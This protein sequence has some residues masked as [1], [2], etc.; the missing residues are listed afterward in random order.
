[1]SSAHLSLFAVEEDALRQLKDDEALP[2]L[3]NGGCATV[4]QYILLSVSVAFSRYGETVKDGRRLENI[5]WRLWHKALNSSEERDENVYRPPTPK[6]ASRPLGKPWLLYCGTFAQSKVETCRR[7]SRVA[8][9]LCELLPKAT[10][11][12][13]TSTLTI[14]QSPINLSDISAPPTASPPTPESEI[15][16]EPCC[17]PVPPDA[18]PVIIANRH[19]HYSCSPVVPQNILLPPPK[20]VIVD[21]TPNPTP[22]PTPPTTPVVPSYLHAMKHDASLALTATVAAAY[23]DSLTVP[24]LCVPGHDAFQQAQMKASSR[25][26][27]LRSPVPEYGDEHRDILSN[28]G[29]RLFGGRRYPRLYTYRRAIVNSFVNDFCYLAPRYSALA[30]YSDHSYKHSDQVTMERVS[31]SPLPS[32]PSNSPPLPQPI[33]AA[34]VVAAMGDSVDPMIRDRHL[35]SSVLDTKTDSLFS[36]PDVTT[37]ATTAM[38]NNSMITTTMVGTEIMTKSLETRSLSP[39]PALCDVAVATV[40]TF[41]DLSLSPVTSTRNQIQGVN[42]ITTTN[43]NSTIVDLTATT[44]PGDDAAAITATIITGA[45]TGTTPAVNSSANTDST[46]STT[47]STSTTVAINPDTTLTLSSTASFSSASPSSNRHP[48]APL[49]KTRS[50]SASTSNGTGSSGHRNR[51][52]SGSSSA[53]RVLMSERKGV[54]SKNTSRSKMGVGRITRVGSDGSTSTV[55]LTKVNLPTTPTTEISTVTETNTRSTD[56]D[57]DTQI[58]ANTKSGGKIPAAANGVSSSSGRDQQNG[59]TQKRTLSGHAATRTPTFA[60]GKHHHTSFT[61]KQFSHHSHTHQRRHPQHQLVKESAEETKPAIVNDATNGAG[62]LNLGSELDDGSGTKSTKKMRSVKSG[63]ESGN[64]S[65]SGGLGGTGEELVIRQQQ[66]QQQEKMNKKEPGEEEEKEKSWILPI[67]KSPEDDAQVRTLSSKEETFIQDKGKA[68]F[69]PS[70]DAINSTATANGKPKYPTTTKKSSTVVPSLHVEATL[71]DPLLPRTTSRKIVVTSGSEDEDDEDFETETEA[72]TDCTGTV[73]RTG[74][75]SAFTDKSYVKGK[76]K[77]KEREGVLSESQQKLKVQFEL[78]QQK[79]K[80]M[81]EQQRVQ[82]RLQVQAQQQVTRPRPRPPLNRTQSHNPTRAT[83]TTTHKHAPSRAH[84]QRALSEQQRAAEDRKWKEELFTKLPTSSFQDSVKI[85]RTNSVPGL[86]S[87]LL[88]PDLQML[89]VDPSLR[90][91]SG[92]GNVGAG[93]DKRGFSSGMIQPLKLLMPLREG[94]QEVEEKIV[95][96]QGQQV[97]PQVIKQVSVQPPHQHEAQQ[98]PP[99]NECTITAEPHPQLQPQE[100]VATPPTLSQP[101]LVDKHPVN[102]VGGGGNQR[103]QHSRTVSRTYRLPKRL[104]VLTIPGGGGAGIGGGTTKTPVATAVMSELRVGSIQG[105]KKQV[106]IGGDGALV[107]ADVNPNA[108][109]SGSGSGGATGIGKGRYKSK[110]PPPE[111]VMEDT[112]GEESDD[113]ENQLDLPKSVAQEK[114]RAL[115]EGQKLKKLAQGTEQQQSQANRQQEVEHRPA[116][117]ISIPPPR[118]YYPYNLPPPNPPTSPRTTR[119]KMLTVE[120]PESLRRNLLWE[121][122]VSQAHRRGLKRSASSGDVAKGWEIPNVVKLTPKWLKQEPVDEEKERL[123]ESR[124][125]YLARTRTW[126]FEYHGAGW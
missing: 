5:S 61:R 70:T 38:S 34:T 124:R 104:E 46:T 88:K 87:R 78:Q 27:H 41:E 66:Q 89:P 110:A 120:I 113:D 31:S 80:Q 117:P 14:S 73:T 59:V 13:P 37:T 58:D 84:T 11:S 82:Q 26:I 60:V 123:K 83:T 10:L 106:V 30:P 12:I 25:Q 68:K 15:V 42:A 24:L 91:H 62:E 47:A 18:M 67:V 107:N 112:S 22:H 28:S 7:L 114:L 50:V 109:G 35:A 96:V 2:R 32:P 33:V 54:R 95:E 105:T 98:A 29:T 55:P 43:S 77:G 101:L 122:Q 52:G 51:I 85:A 63:M 111:T 9:V 64:A 8:K 56:V 6:E 3:W 65:I 99:V 36:S 21:P 125:R 19:R 71:A 4:A 115:L 23:S 92:D 45:N 39:L 72:E 57:A 116:E 16:E 102:D 100:T 74:T 17:P 53:I 118:M 108:S 49:R 76:G 1:M 81:L 86:L 121:R 119:R 75:G 94:Q 40:P 90:N 44:T 97:Q 126:L 48:V 103:S 20:L 79:K 93:V 69:V